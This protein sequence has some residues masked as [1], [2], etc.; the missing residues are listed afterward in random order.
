MFIVKIYDGPSDQE[1]VTVHSPSNSPVKLADGQI[2][3]EINAIDSFDFTMLPNNPAFRKVNLYTGLVNVYNTKTKEYDFEGRIL[4]P[5]EEMDSDGALTYT[6]TA[7]GELAYLY[8]SVQQHMEFRGTTNELFETLLTYHN[9]QVEEYKH[10]QVGTVTVQDPNDYMY[11][12]LN[13]EEKT[14]DAIKR[15]LLDKLGGELRIRKENGVRYLDYVEMIGIQSSVK[16]ELSKNLISLSR[17]IDPSNIITRLTPLG[18]RIESDDPDATDASQERLTIKSV[19]NGVPYIDRP[20][21]IDVFG[22]RGGS[23]TWD[24][25]ATPER[26]KTNGQNWLDNQKLVLYQYS[27]EALDLSLIGLDPSSFKIGNRHITNNP[28]MNIANEILRIVKLKIDINRP[29]KSS[30]TIGDKFKTQTDMQRDLNAETVYIRHLENSVAGLQS[31]SQALRNTLT[32]AQSR[33]ET[34]QQT[35]VN[36]NADNLPES[37]SEIGLQLEALQQAINNIEVPEYGLA[38]RNSDGLMSATDKRK[39]DDLIIPD[40]SDELTIINATLTNLTDR[41][42]ALEGA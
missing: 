34:V 7:E 28:V 31:Q 36:I 20:D 29:Q 10:F 25:V 38:T 14:Y 24:D 32:E 6:Y 35:L 19:N 15:T 4:A 27:I 40:Y 17:A 13:A 16:I 30:L 3:K 8:D 18:T 26:L 9:S 33:L 21:L 42:E 22:I 12:Y 1:G 2:N 11:L 39:L 5:D 37:M 41:I 23:E